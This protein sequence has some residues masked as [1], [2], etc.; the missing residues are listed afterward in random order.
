MLFSSNIFIF[1]FLPASLAGYWLLTRLGRTALL[2]WLTFVSL[3][4]YGYWNPAYLLLLAGSIL[5][6]FFISYAIDEGRPEPSRSLWLFLGILA[7]LVLLMYYKYLFPTLNFFHAH[8]LL[9]RGFANVVLPLGIS[10]FT[11]TQIAYL[12]DLRQGIAK[13][14]DILSYSI[15]V[16]FFPHLIAGPII[17][18][19]ELMPQFD[20]GRIHGLRAD[21]LALGVTWFILGLAKKVLIADRV[22]PL[23]DVMYAHPAS[24]GFATTWLGALAYSVQLYFDFSGYSD[25]ALGLARMFSIEFPI[26]FH[27][28]Y[29]TQ[30]IIDFW[31]HW[32]MT[33]TRYLTDYVYTPILREVN[34]RRI[35]AGKKATRKAAATP[36]G[37]VQIVF[38]P[39]L[40][41]MFISGIWHGAGLQFLLWG[42][43][44]GF[45]LS[46]NHAWRLFTPPGSRLHRV[47]P[48][49]FMV[50]LTF[51]CVLFGLVLFR[52]ANV[53][54]AA[55]IVATMAG[56]HGAG[57]SFAAF[58]Y[59]SEIPS[60]S[61][62][63]VHESS[64]IATLAICFFI[65]WALPNT[66]EILGQLP[67]DQ[68]RK[69]SL[70]P[71]L[72]W[73]PSALWSFGITLLLCAAILLLDASTRFLYFQF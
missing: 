45:Y 58:Q 15:F 64:A 23:A 21:D 53:H 16:T 11:F 28:P 46:V 68:V 55:H 40:T 3:F 66:Q 69:P 35:E 7:N 42:S 31:Q 22:A 39:I 59:L 26:N 25:M 43:L 61:R 50:L 5:M 17:H 49:P 19:R 33:L 52:A 36:E 37:F 24:A 13:R 32:H 47:V 34:A 67:R 63:M 73:R 1:L 38:F 12:I 56:I 65:V 70:L 8:G 51:I 20:Q 41:T 6:N 14:Q 62:F 60:V 71:R 27:S 2:T 4:F 29:K 48:A 72:T 18:P 57:P 30:N 10:F 54:D 9:A 44:H